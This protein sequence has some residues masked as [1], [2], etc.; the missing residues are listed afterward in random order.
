MKKIIVFFLVFTN[1]SVALSSSESDPLTTTTSVELTKCE[2][3][4]LEYTNLSN[5]LFNTSFELNTFIDDISAG[6]I[7]EDRTY[8]FENLDKNW[9]YQEIYLNYLEVRFEVYSKINAL[10]ANNSECPI[11]GD[12]EISLEQVDSAKSDLEEFKKKYNN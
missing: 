12:Q 4:E 8:F 1:C 3:L 5:K 11:S 2:K 10:Y 7:N 9:N 6:S